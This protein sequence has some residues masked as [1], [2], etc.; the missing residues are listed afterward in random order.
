MRGLPNSRQLNG[1]VVARLGLFS[2]LPLKEI[3][4]DVAGLST[5][6]ARSRLN[7]RW[8]AEAEQFQGQA[9]P[10]ISARARGLKQIRSN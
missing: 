7:G 6:P 8:A 2:S 5:W 1:H 4:S 3:R 9:V 10:G